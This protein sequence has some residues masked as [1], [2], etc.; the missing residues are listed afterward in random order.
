[1]YIYIY[2]YTVPFIFI[3]KKK[4]RT[5]PPSVFTFVYTFVIQYLKNLMDQW[6]TLFT[7]LA[8]W[9]LCWNRGRRFWDWITSYLAA[10]LAAVAGRLREIVDHRHAPVRLSHTLSLSQEPVEFL[11]FGSGS[12]RSL[13]FQLEVDKVLIRCTLEVVSNQSPS[14]YGCLFL[15][16]EATGG[17]RPSLTFLLWMSMSAKQSS[18]RRWYHQFCPL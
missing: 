4:L 15:A 1:M 11:S 8:P 18:G 14:F 6:L 9:C 13:A 2:W 17:R 5:F 10:V 3:L 7:Y 16:E 12:C